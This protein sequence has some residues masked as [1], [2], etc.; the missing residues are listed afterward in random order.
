MGVVF[1]MAFVMAPRCRNE[2]TFIPS[3]YTYPCP[4]AVAAGLKGYNPNPDILLPSNV[5]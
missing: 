3:S 5:F 2:L 1:R 4:D